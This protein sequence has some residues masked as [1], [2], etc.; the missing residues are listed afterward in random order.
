MSFSSVT[1]VLL[2]LHVPDFQNVKEYYGNLGFTVVWERTP[3]QFKGYV[4]MK[5]ENNI[6]CFWAGNDFVYQH[7]YFKKFSNKTVRGYGVEIVIIVANIES[8]Y[9]KVKDTARG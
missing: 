4:V 2:E 5:M 1:T 7:P 8:Y 6:L 9:K 3:D